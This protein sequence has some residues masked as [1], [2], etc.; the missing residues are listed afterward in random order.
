MIMKAKMIMLG[1]HALPGVAATRSTSATG[2]SSAC[3]FSCGQPRHAGRGDA[4]P[5]RR[6][7]DTR[8]GFAHGGWAVPRGDDV[9]VARAGERMGRDRAFLFGRRT[10]EELLAS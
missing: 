2:H 4:R 3:P 1:E 7:E 6:D 9:I 10:Y 8:G 5:G